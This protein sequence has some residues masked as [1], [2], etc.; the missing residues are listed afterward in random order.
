VISTEASDGRE[1]SAIASANE[2]GALSLQFC[3]ACE[4]WN[5]F[6]RVACPSCFRDALEW[7]DASGEGRL[8]SVAVVRRTHHAVYEPHLPIV[9]VLIELDEGCEMVS[10]IVGD[11]RLEAKIGDRVRVASDGR[12]SELPQFRRAA[13]PG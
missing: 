5:W 9:L 7:R 3:R 6:P 11:D 10:T 2:R 1:R 12:W 13:Y 4:L 8:V